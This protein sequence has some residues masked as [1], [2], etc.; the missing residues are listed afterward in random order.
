MEVDSFSQFEA[1]LQRHPAIK[2]KDNV[3]RELKQCRFVGMMPY[4]GAAV[5]RAQDSEALQVRER[6]FNSS[7]EEAMEFVEGTFFTCFKTS[8]ASLS[9]A[10]YNTTGWPADV[11]QI[12][13]K[14]SR[15]QARWVV[16]PKQIHIRCTTTSAPMRT[17]PPINGSPIVCDGLELD[18]IRA[19]L[20]VVGLFAVL[21]RVDRNRRHIDGSL[22]GVTPRRRQA[23]QGIILESIPKPFFDVLPIELLTQA[24]EP[25]ADE[26]ASVAFI[27]KPSQARK[28]TEPG[29]L[30]HPVHQTHKLVWSIQNRDATSYARIEVPQMAQIE[31]CY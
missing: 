29:V 14:T 5:P 30:L 4:E 25:C 12:C 18:H 13:E 7:A 23:I 9:L 21:V 16:S 20:A 17:T 11:A 2:E 28:A 31:P 8:L 26:A 27:S 24:C 19:I 22:D 6:C 15:S 1:T 3:N 10:P